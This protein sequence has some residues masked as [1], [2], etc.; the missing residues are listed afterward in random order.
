MHPTSAAPLTHGTT[1]ITIC[2]VT[3]S[4]CFTFRDCCRIFENTLKAEVDCI[5][6]I[7]KILLRRPWSRAI[8]SLH[9]LRAAVL[10]KSSQVKALVFTIVYYSR[11]RK[12]SPACFHFINSISKS[13]TTYFQ[14]NRS[15][16]KGI[17][18]YFHCNSISS[19]SITTYFHC[20][21][22]ISKGITTYLHCNR[23]I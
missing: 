5:F 3:F 17:T 18:T 19:N 14:C 4:L 9:L 12:S 11:V 6:Q 20:N 13:I 1:L 16:S 23:S 2:T 22:S 7:W 15:K 10:T 8:S 21:S